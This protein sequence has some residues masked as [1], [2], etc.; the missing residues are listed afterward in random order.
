M[1]RNPRK[2]KWTKAFR[3]AA[4]KEMVVDSTLQFA[5]RRNIPVRYNRDLMQKTLKAMESNNNRR[6]SEIRSRRERVFYKRRMAGKR[7]TELANDRRL[8]NT[9]S[10]LLPRVRGS[11]KRRLAE[12]ARERGAEEL[13]EAALQDLAISEAQADAEAKKATKV[14]GKEK[15]RLRVRVDGGVEVVPDSAAAM[16]VDGDDDMDSE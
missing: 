14:F 11:E 2:L 5:A 16:D 3:K 15:Q 7:A 13:N 9:H 6:I 10:H 4:G 8:V 12:L 1:K